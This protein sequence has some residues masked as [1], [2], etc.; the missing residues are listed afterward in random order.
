MDSTEQVSDKLLHEIIQLEVEID[1]VMALNGNREDFVVKQYRKFIQ[2]K[3][4]RL[5]K[6]NFN[7]KDQFHPIANK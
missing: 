2:A 6:I 7:Y 3:R 4:N 5:K 1:K